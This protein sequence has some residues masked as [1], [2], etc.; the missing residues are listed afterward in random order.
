MNKADS[1]L[2]ASNP[3]ETSWSRLR[4]FNYY[5]GLLTILFLTVY[6]Q[7]W[8]KYLIQPEHFIPTLFYTVSVL[9][10]IAFLV[11]AI[12]IYQRKP[13]LN[14]QVMLQ[15]VIDVLAIIT[16]MHASGSI[17][18]GFGMLLIISISMAGMYLTRQLALL[19]AASASLAVLGEHFYSQMTLSNIQPQ[20]TQVGILGTL[21]FATVFLTSYITIRLRETEQLAS[22]Q[23]EDLESAVQMNEHVIRNMRT[24]IM[25]VAPDGTIQM[26]NNAAESLLGNVYIAK[27]QSLNK[28]S[29]AL[30][31]RLNE[32]RDSDTMQ[33]IPIQ[34]QHGLPD[35]QP[36][37]SIF[38]PHKGKQSRT[39][40]FLEDASQ[41]N[42]R[43][44]QVKLASL[45]RLTASI[46]HE[47]R[48]PLAAIHHASQLLEESNHDPADTKLTHIISTQVQRLNNVVES[49]L[50]LSRQQRGT[51]ETIKLNKWL[52]EFR[53]EY[54]S[55]GRLGEDQ[56]NIHIEPKTT[57]IQFNSEHLH[58]VLWNLCTNA[59]NHSGVAIEE[60]IISI[61]G[62]NTRD[63]NQPFLDIIDNGAG[64]ENDV[65][66]QIFEPFYTTNQD[67]SGLGLYITKEVV[68]S[69]RAKIRYIAL[70][71]GGTCFR[72]YFIQPV[73]S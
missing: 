22:Q 57:R 63:L 51:S 35:I 60:L 59:I 46:A 32:W 21:I 48:N 16:L 15:I 26:A 10:F 41:L 68:E 29:P 5:R 3:P 52:T 25:V 33:Q 49:V 65:A 72:I 31:K 39:L 62:G 70:P 43:F 1:N 14:I 54:C 6:F 24:G 20:Y 9:Y 58:Q 56:I 40:I 73:Q 55:S 42:Q 44:Q 19:F 11:F 27:S 7:G 53:H 50:Q 30:L 8:T 34:Q 38:E 17:R 12:G 47:I 18:S 2:F 64:I 61:Q 36:G 66:Q 45:G 67:G 71:T 23:S 4:I 37:F 28:I 69:N 13:D